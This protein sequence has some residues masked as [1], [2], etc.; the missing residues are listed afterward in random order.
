ME[1]FNYMNSIAPP[2]LPFLWLNVIPNMFSIASKTVLARYR[3]GG[4]ADLQMVQSY[5]FYILS[6]TTLAFVLSSGNRDAGAIASVAIPCLLLCGLYSFFFIG[7]Q[8]HAASA[9]GVLVAL[10]VLPLAQFVRPVLGVLGCAGMWYL[11]VQW[12]RINLKNMLAL[13]VFA[14]A[15]FGSS[16][17]SDFEYIKYLNKGNI[18]IDSFFHIAIAAMYKNYGVASLG[19]DGLVPIS[20]HTLSHKVLAGISVLSQENVMATY[21]RLYFV[22]GPALLVFMLAAL[23]IRIQP[24]QTFDNALLNVSV[25]MLAVRCLPVF[26]EFGFWDSYF[27]SES[28]LLGLVLLVAAILALIQFRESPHDIFGLCCAFALLIFSGLSKASVGFL[29]FCIFGLFG[30]FV[31]RTP[32][33]WIAL[34]VGAVMFCV[35]I[36]DAASSG[37]VNIR[38]QP[39]DF[40]DNYVPAFGVANESIKTLLFFLVHF[41]PVWGCFFF[42]IFG[43]GKA[44][45]YTNEFL[46]LIGLFLPALGIISLLQ[47]AGGSAFYFS[48]VPVVLAFSFAASH[49]AI[50][51]QSG[52]IPLLLAI[53]TFG[54]LNYFGLLDFVEWGLIKLF[55]LACLTFL[56]TNFGAPY[57]RW[58]ALLFIVNVA[59]RLLPAVIE[60]RTAKGDRD[61]GV[62]ISAEVSQLMA[63]RDRL[64]LDSSVRVLNA[65]LLA[66]KMGCPAFWAIPAI[67]ERP[68]VAGLPG[69]GWC[70]E[71]KNVYYGLSDYK[72][73]RAGVVLSNIH[74]IELK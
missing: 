12:R 57:K 25:L 16:I 53:G 38:L 42:G 65:S 62:D 71:Y 22:L 63:V 56:L 6:I 5:L 43:K 45:G 7:L 51:K 50:K 35:V 36:L 30:L 49:M 2:S 59:F 73:P 18:S 74:V 24:R 68:I 33:F 8:S 31:L 3:H 47:I 10:M 17:H 60:P 20:Y 64:P 1:R 11:I 29:G 67:L 70:T 37:G 19:L 26:K 41:S 66:K 27:S 39:L 34:L 23:A 14:I 15:L 13:P 46:V 58:I 52:W 21:A 44:Y 4:D 61:D 28:Y 9:I 32:K 54:G 55:L 40:I 72:Y 48:N 69:D